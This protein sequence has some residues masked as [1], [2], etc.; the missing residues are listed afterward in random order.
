MAF[1]E[2]DDTLWAVQVQAIVTTG[3]IPLMKNGIGAPGQ[4]VPVFP[5]RSSL[6]TFE[7]RFSLSKIIF[8]LKKSDFTYKKPLSDI[9]FSDSGFNLRGAG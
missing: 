2:L 3:S 5:W 9:E 6:F 4:R 7:I 8:Q 1:N